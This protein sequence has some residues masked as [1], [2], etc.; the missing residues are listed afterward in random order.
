MVDEGIARSNALWGE[1]NETG[2]RL[3]VKLLLTD[4]LWRAF[5]PSTIDDHPTYSAIQLQLCAFAEISFSH[6]VPLCGG[7][8]VL[9]TG[10][11]DMCFG[12]GDDEY[13]SL[14]CDTFLGVLEITKTEDFEKGF[15]QL[16]AYLGC[17]PSSSPSRPGIL[18]V[19]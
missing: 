13:K 6:N 17:S 1:H 2:R 19:G 18:T 8:G 7:G 10:N 12:F 4:T 14:W 11:C 5:T 15:P 3:I 9:I 16:L